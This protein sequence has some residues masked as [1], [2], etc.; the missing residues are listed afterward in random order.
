MNDRH[1]IMKFE[2]LPNEILI[3][4]F[5]YLNAID[6]FHSF[7]YLNSRF[8]NLIRSISLSFDIEHVKEPVLVQFCI[9]ILLHRQMKQ[10]IKSLKLSN[11]NFETLFS[12]ISLNEY[13]QLQSLTLI[14]LDIEN[15]SR[16]SSMLPLL[17]N[18]CHFRMT[19]KRFELHEILNAL[20]AS[21]IKIL[22]IPKLPQHINFT[23][24]FTSL[25]NLSVSQ[26]SVKRLCHF[27]KYSPNLKYLTVERVSEYTWVTV[28]ELCS[29]D[30]PIVHLKQLVIHSFQEEFDFLEVLLKRT[31]NLEVLV[32]SADSDSNFVDAN[33]WQHSITTSLL[34]LYVFKFKFDID[35][36]N[37]DNG[38]IDQFQQ[39]QSDFWHQQHHWYTEYTL[40]E[41]T[42]LI[43]T[44]PYISNKY[45]IIPYT[46]RCYNESISN[47]NTLV[48]VTELNLCPEAMTGENEYYFP[49][50]KLLRL[51]E[52][53]T[54]DNYVYSFLK[55]KHIECLKTMVN[56]SCLIRLEMLPG[57]RLKSPSV[58]LLL[59]KESPNLSSLKISKIILFS[60]LNNRELCGYF[61]KM[62]TK[63]D[64]TG[65]SICAD[66]TYKEV[67][68]VAETFSNIEEFRCDVGELGNLMFTLNQLS[69]LP[70]MK[71]FCY[72]T[73]YLETQY[74]Q[75]E[76]YIPQSK[77]YSFAIECERNYYVDD[78][79]D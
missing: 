57:S 5:E 43:Y 23:H 44:I 19:D 54:N 36:E 47:R 30:N 48:N 2:L 55:T 73:F 16:I 42:A 34:H 33:R 70:N 67:I 46:K 4:C 65:T 61:N 9:E 74:C 69:K 11:N 39:F 20:P 31:P 77:L 17:T 38:I 25:V 78:F 13:S 62:I 22:S 40:N 27:F 8:N 79:S 75:V 6:I 56:L 24:P 64:I 14:D 10:K 41:G 1:S 76:P 26:C 53:R 52:G 12:F 28:D 66:L 15:I 51:A 63:L 50:V 72:R 68:Q 35:F 21:T 60:L 45:E 18:L 58:M 37:E 3:E 49:N 71:F 29:F 59:L 32:L 7:D